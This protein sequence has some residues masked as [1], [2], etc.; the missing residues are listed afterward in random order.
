[1]RISRPCYDKCH[2]CPGW[3]GGGLKFAKVD[4]C[5]NGKITFPFNKSFTFLGKYCRVTGFGHCN[6]C[7]VLVLPYSIRLLD[8]TYWKCEIVYKIDSIKWK[9]RNKR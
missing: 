9:L 5:D 4:R 3:I 8:P 7:D 1:M 6:R 2:R